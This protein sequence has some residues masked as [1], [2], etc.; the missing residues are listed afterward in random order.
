MSGNTQA[1]AVSETEL[2]LGGH[3]S[4]F[5]EQRIRR[6]FLASADPY[7]GVATTWDTK[8]EGLKPGVWALLID[9]P[10]LH[11]GGQF[12][13]FGTDPQKGYARFTG[14]P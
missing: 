7:T 12:T 6:P 1:F 3:F 8:A 11:V 4:Q 13:R 2:Y 5:A 9:G 14:T 10:H